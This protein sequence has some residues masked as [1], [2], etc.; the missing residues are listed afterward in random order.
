MANQ[1]PREIEEL[2]LKAAP[3]LGDVHDMIYALIVALERKYSLEDI[4]EALEELRD[5]AKFCGDLYD[6]L[7]GR[8]KKPDPMDIARWAR[9]VA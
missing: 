2:I 8:P 1:T 5:A 6:K 3:D 4:E 7:E 9:E